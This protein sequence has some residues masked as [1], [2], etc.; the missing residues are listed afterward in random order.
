[1]LATVKVKSAHTNT[2]GRQEKEDFP[3]P[4]LGVKRAD[5]DRAD[6]IA[7]DARFRLSDLDG[8]ES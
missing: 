8:R 6:G 2:A 1:M 3:Y 7:D 5:G 4:T